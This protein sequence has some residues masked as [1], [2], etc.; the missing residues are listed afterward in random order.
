MMVYQNRIKRIFIVSMSVMLFQG[1]IL[2][3]AHTAWCQTGQEIT[4]TEVYYLAE[5]ID[6]ALVRQYELS[7]DAFT[8]K[9]ISD[10]LRSRNVYQKALTVVEEFV[11]LH[12]NAID[13]NVLL[14]AQNVDASATQPKDI[15][16]LIDR[17]RVYL[18]KQERSVSVSGRQSPTVTDDAYTTS[19]P[20][21]EQVQ[22]QRETKTPSDV[23]QM[24]RQITWHH[25]EIANKQNITT[26]W[27]AVPRVYEAVVR[28]ILSAV[29]AMADDARLEYEDYPFPP[30]PVDG[31]IPRNIYKILTHVYQHI[32]TYYMQTR[33]YDPL[34]LIEVNDCDEVTRADVFDL[35]QVI[36][37]E[38]K[39][40]IGVRDLAAA[41]AEQ[42]AKWK[43]T[44]ETVVP[45][46]TFRLLQYTY[47]LTKRVLEN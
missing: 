36:T 29:Q 15:Y 10:N 39:V 22:T 9:H 26:D 44:H 33:T 45:G 21:P 13:R 3:M 30:Q 41:T 38:L 47:I 2:I 19:Q 35:I 31:V 46:H 23:Y 5:S 20:A 1:Q 17:M 4:P 42:Y 40:E 14:A 28:N 43:E 32:T 7:E 34:V 12:P 25:I 27:A 16:A 18:E 8:K 24:L 37:A 11:V 6:Q